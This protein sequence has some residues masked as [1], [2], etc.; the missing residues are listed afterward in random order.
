MSQF[1][2]FETLQRPDTPNTYLV[3]PG[4]VKSPS[5]ADETS[6]VFGESPAALF[7]R[8]QSMVS[9]RD[10]WKLGESD[11]AEH[12]LEFVAVTKLLKFKDDISLKAYPAS[13]DG[14][15]SALAVYSRSRVGKYDF[16]ANRKRVQSLLAELK[17]NAAATA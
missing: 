8:V 10:D 1:T 13:E 5:E 15:T 16:N 11:D 17:G 7:K 12:Q 4:N 14:Q 9:G 3:L 2:S 6:P